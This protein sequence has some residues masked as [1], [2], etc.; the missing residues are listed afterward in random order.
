ML[1]D[2]GSSSGIF[3]DAKSKYFSL[4]FGGLPSSP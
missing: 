1:I 2:L 4:E 3:V